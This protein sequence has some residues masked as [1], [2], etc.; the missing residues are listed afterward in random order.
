LDQEDG[1][2]NLVLTISA[3][4]AAHYQALLQHLLILIR[5]VRVDINC[6][7]LAVLWDTLALLLDVIYAE[8]QDNIA[9]QVD[10][11]A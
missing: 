10:G 5:N 9:A 4:I 3:K 11:I 2:A 1:I 7:G 6:N 8:K